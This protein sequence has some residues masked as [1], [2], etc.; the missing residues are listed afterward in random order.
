VKRSKPAMFSFNCSAMYRS[1]YI[2]SHI[3]NYFWAT[4]YTWTLWLTALNDIIYKCVVLHVWTTFD[5]VYARLGD[6]VLVLDSWFLSNLTYDDPIKGLFFS[7]VMLYQ[8]C[9]KFSALMYFLVLNIR[10][11]NLPQ[12][13]PLKSVKRN[14]IQLTKET[15]N[16]TLVLWM[17][18]YYVLTTD[19]FQLLKLPYA[20]WYVQ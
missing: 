13:S 18:L 14:C 2:A 20:M 19:M 15:N 11:T 8:S 12:S 3:L 7:F 16:C 10:V 5:G 4:D 9:W 6:C 17:S 1:F